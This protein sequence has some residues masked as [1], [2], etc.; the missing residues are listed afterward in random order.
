[1]HNELAIL[2]VESSSELASQPTVVGG[3]ARNVPS[4]HISRSC[5]GWC[6]WIAAS[7][8]WHMYWEAPHWWHRILGVSSPHMKQAYRRVRELSN[9]FIIL[10]TWLVL[11]HSVITYR[12]SWHWWVHDYFF[13]Q[14]AAKGFPVLITS[15]HT[16]SPLSFW[17]VICYGHINTPEKVI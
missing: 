13:K 11:V 4:H 1:M 2:W 16:L 7:H 12:I 6:L 10:Y 3:I 17:L 15:V 9:S 14:F 8:V 5:K